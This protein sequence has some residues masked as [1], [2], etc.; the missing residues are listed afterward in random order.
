MSTPDVYAVGHYNG[1]PPQFAELA[2]DEAVSGVLGQQDYDRRRLVITQHAARGSLHADLGDVSFFPWGDRQHAHRVV[3]VAGM[4]GPGTFD[5]ASLR[6]LVGELAV[7]VTALPPAVRICTVLIGS[8]E[9]TLT[10]PQAVRG[11]LDGIADAAQEIFTSGIYDTP[12]QRSSSQNSTAGVPRT[13]TPRSNGSSSAALPNSGPSAARSWAAVAEPGGRCRS[14]RASPSPSRAWWRRPVRRTAHR[15]NRRSPRSCR[16]AAPTR[17]CASSPS[18]DCGARAP[19]RHL[20]GTARASASPAGRPIS[21]G[22]SPGRISFWD[23]GKVI[24][25]AAIDQAATVPERVVGVARDV[26]DDLT[27]R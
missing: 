25:A 22:A 4:G 19:I 9:G 24:R 13:S 10:I 20:D 11:W 16:A 27:A 6:R 12:V 7:A 5:T 2:L 8:G 26:V 3:A 23:D 21:A 14:R 15:N 18:S 17:S 1:V